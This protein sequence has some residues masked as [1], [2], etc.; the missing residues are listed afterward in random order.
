MKDLRP[1]ATFF[2]IQAL[3]TPK[4]YI[5]T[6]KLYA[7]NILCHVGLSESHPA[8]TLA[9]TKHQSSQ[10]DNIPYNN[11]TQFRQLIGALQYLTITRSDIS[12]IVNKLCQTMHHP[13]NLHF[14][15]LK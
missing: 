10:A 9:A 6:Q 5:L 14:Q 12:Y 2:G 13:A 8:V 7:H 3:L 15:Q 11:P 4:G 1:L